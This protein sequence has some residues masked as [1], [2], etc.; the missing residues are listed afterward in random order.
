MVD[1]NR[2]VCI[3]KF[4]FLIKILLNGMKWNEINQSINVVCRWTIITNWPVWFVSKFLSNKIIMWKYK[5][6]MI[7]GVFFSP[8]NPIAIFLW[9]TFS[10]IIS[11]NN[12]NQRPWPLV[13]LIMIWSGKKKFLKIIAS[14]N[15]ENARKRKKNSSKKL[16]HQSSIFVVVV[17]V[18]LKPIFLWEKK[19]ETKW[20]CVCVFFFLFRSE[21]VNYMKSKFACILFF[22]SNFNFKKK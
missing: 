14:G 17:V 9:H 13:S 10:H 12:N 6:I 4:F 11:I 2:S 15:D 3:E 16:F 8:S 22:K 20:I 7:T 19:I 5:I 18:N 1:W 21:T